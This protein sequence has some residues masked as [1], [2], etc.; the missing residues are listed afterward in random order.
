MNALRFIPFF[1][2]ML[3][4]YNAV[5]FMGSGDLQAPMFSIGLISGASVTFTT[6]TIM[7][8][9]G[10]LILYLEI[11]KSTKTSVATIIDHTLSMIV[12][13]IFLVEFLVVPQA[14]NSTFFILILLSLLD[15]IAGFTITISTAKRDFTVPDQG[16]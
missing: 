5:V 14:G 12:F 13:V 2:F 8:T 15:V 6:S 1:A 7:L 11:L 10:M 16:F 3:I 9:F 4:I